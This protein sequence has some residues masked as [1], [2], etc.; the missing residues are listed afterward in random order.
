M[1][2]SDQRRPPAD[3]PDPL[4]VFAPRCWFCQDPNPRG[5]AMLA[6]QTGSGTKIAACAEGEGCRDGRIFH[7]PTGNP[8]HFPDQDC[9]VCGPGARRNASPGAASTQPRSRVGRKQPR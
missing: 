3:R 7:G 2:P 4:R 8:P 9:K 1:S 5:Y 6:G